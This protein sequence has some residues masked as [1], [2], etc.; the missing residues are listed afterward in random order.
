MHEGQLILPG[1][2]QTGTRGLQSKRLGSWSFRGSASETLT[3]ACRGESKPRG[4]DAPTASAGSDVLRGLADGQIRREVSSKR[5]AAPPPSTLTDPISLK[6][7]F[8]GNTFKKGGP[9]TQG[10]TLNC[11]KPIVIISF[12]FGRFRD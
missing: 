2:N 8:G 7:W 11:F 3:S 9:P 6:R 12:P 4:N 1:E 10:I 5:G